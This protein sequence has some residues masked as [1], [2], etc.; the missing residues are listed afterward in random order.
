MV[1][2]K[3]IAP[4]CSVATQLKILIPV[5]T[6]ISTVVY[7]MNTRSQWGMP[8]VNMWCAQTRK[9]RMAMAHSAM[10]MD[11]RPK[12]GLRDMG[13]RTSGKTPNVGR[14]MTYTAGCE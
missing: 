5:G 7:D 1:V 13:E 2:W 12:M 4:L 6:A 14:I 9:P 10:T 3:R 8:E 11:F